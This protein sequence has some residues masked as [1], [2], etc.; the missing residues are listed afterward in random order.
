MFHL[1]RCH[2]F[3]TSSADSNTG[4]TCNVLVDIWKAEIGK[5]GD[6]KKYK[7]D[8]S[9]IRIPG[10]VGRFQE[11]SYVYHF[12]RLTI[13]APIDLINTPWHL[14]KTGKKFAD[15]MVFLGL[16]WNF[17]E[18]RVSLP[19]D[20]RLKHLARVQSMKLSIEAHLVFALLNLQELHR[21]LSATSASSTGRD[22]LTSQSSRMQ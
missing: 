20:K 3:G 11:N 12:D 21:A 13:E 22:L 14:M 9:I 18:S 2:P 16:D 15:W 1:D 4:Q 10:L 5:D 8:L 7:D 19:T 17:P 6:V